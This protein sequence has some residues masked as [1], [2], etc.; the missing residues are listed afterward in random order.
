MKA[1]AW[2]TAAVWCIAERATGQAPPAPPVSKP[3]EL[4][5][6]VVLP[7]VQGRLDHMAA[8]VAHGRLFVAATGNGSLE[9]IDLAKDERSGRVTGLLGPQGV[10][11]VPSTGAV[12]VTCGG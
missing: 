6:T 4:V 9:V 12:V 7:D 2:M 8:D 10:V 11:F 3:P 5:Q 1:M